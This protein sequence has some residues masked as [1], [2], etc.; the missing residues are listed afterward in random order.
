MGVKIFIF[1]FLIT[2]VYGS[3]CSLYG[4]CQTSDTAPCLAD[5]D[6]KRV[7]I[8]RLDGETKLAFNEHCPKFNLDQALCCDHDQ[9]RHLVQVLNGDIREWFERCPSCYQNIASL[10]CAITC[11]PNQANYVEATKLSPGDRHPNQIWIE[12]DE[13]YVTGIYESCKYIRYWRN[14]SMRALDTFCPNCFDF[15]FYLKLIRNYP[16]KYDRTKG[17]VTSEAAADKLGTKPLKQDTTPCDQIAP[18]AESACECIDCPDTRCP[19]MPPETTTQTQMDSG[20]LAPDGNKGSGI[21]NSLNLI[22][23]PVAII[24]MYVIMI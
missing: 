7:E 13:S 22:L 24:F 14:D 16:L 17:I 11:D 3:K 12:A 19:T 5:T 10:Y 21:V 20:T 8:S 2:S 1:S 4:I 9:I 23:F 18:G 6:P 15:D